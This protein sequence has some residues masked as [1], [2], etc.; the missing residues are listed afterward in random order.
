MSI[1]MGQHA[2]DEPAAVEAGLRWLATH[3][4][5]EPLRF[6]RYALEDPTSESAAALGALIKPTA[7]LPEVAPAVRAFA[8]WGLITDIV[9]GIGSASDSRRRNTLLAAFRLPPGQGVGTPWKAT[10]DDRF[11][12]LKR[13]GAFGDPPPS[14]TT[15]MHRAWKRALVEQLVPRLLRKFE[16]LSGDGEMWRPYVEIG[17]ATNSTSP[18]AHRQVLPDG[19]AGFR[20][21]SQGAQPVFMERMVVM[22]EMHRRAVFRRFTERKVVACDDGV[23][24]YVARAL[25]GW[26]DRLAAVPIKALWAC[27]LEALQGEHPGDPVLAKLRFTKP[28]KRDQRLTFTSKAFEERSDEEHYWVDVH[29]DH[30]GIA[31]GFLDADGDPSAGLTIRITFDDLSL[32][33]SAWW[34]AE[35]TDDERMR[36]PPSGDRHLLPVE[37][38]FVQ[39]TFRE[40]CHPRENYGLGFRWP[41]S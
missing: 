29:V 39:H 15:P 16:Q 19:I 35:Q 7:S 3:R 2:A 26:T 1:E 20:T 38:G 12:Q 17:R 10:L 30:H 13:C 4:N 28:L 40:P 9:G 14:T 6:L 21:P 33:E 24:G 22:V 34:Y 8:I 23:D 18:P 36:R 31:P 37:D 25:I 32:P 5:G 27:R 41:S 11:E